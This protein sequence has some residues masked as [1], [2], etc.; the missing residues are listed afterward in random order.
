MAHAR[1]DSMAGATQD[2]VPVRPHLCPAS[3]QVTSN[4]G[5]HIRCMHGLLCLLNRTGIGLGRRSHSARLLLAQWLRDALAHKLLQ[6]PL[7][8]CSTSKLTVSTVK[9]MYR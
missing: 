2:G 8:S 1:I 6:P 4:A 9:C 3:A 5:S 7:P